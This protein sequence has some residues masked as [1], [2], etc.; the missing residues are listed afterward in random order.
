MFQE[1]MRK[2]EKILTDN[3]KRE[4]EKIKKNSS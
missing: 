1:K 2:Y 4:Y 3:A